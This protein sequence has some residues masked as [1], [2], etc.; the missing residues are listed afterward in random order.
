MLKFIDL[1]FSV[2]YPLL[3]TMELGTKFVGTRA[4]TRTMMLTISSRNQWKKFF[5]CFGNNLTAN[6]NEIV[7]CSRG[8]LIELV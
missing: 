2:E 4:T 5:K 1:F 8:S 7:K 6:S 3:K